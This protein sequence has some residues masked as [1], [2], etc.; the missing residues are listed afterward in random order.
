L[1]L[2]HAVETVAGKVKHGALV[3]LLHEISNEAHVLVEEI[4]ARQDNPLHKVGILDVALD[5]IPEL[6]HRNQAAQEVDEP[7]ADDRLP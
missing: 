5:A 2:D 7:R 4:V 3:E 6:L 1:W